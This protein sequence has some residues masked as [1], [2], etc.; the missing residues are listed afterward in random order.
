LYIELTHQLEMAFMA[1]N[2][3]AFSMVVQ[4]AIVSNE[5]NDATRPWSWLQPLV[6]YSESE[7]SED[8]WSTESEGED[9]DEGVDAAADAGSVD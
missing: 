6:E 9:D 1:T 5:D 4:G 3:A 8:E 2:D 7:G